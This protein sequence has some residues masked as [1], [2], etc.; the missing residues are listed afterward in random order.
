[1]DPSWLDLASFVGAPIFRPEVPKPF[2]QAF[3]GQFQNESPE[4]SMMEPGKVGGCLC[5][6]P[7]MQNFT[8]SADFCRFTPSPGN[9]EGTGT[10]RTRPDLKYYHVG[11]YCHSSHS[12]FLEISW[13]FCRDVPDPWDRSKIRDSGTTRKY[14]K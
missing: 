13:E 2:K 4:K 9:L 7:E 8:E 5:C 12:L 1:M 10:Q 6:G 3:W 14:S 11:I